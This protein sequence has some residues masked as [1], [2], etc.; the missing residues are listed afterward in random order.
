MRVLLLFTY[1]EKMHL[2]IGKNLCIFLEQMRKLLL[3]NVFVL[4]SDIHL[5]WRM[6]F[7]KEEDAKQTF[8]F[9]SLMNR[10]RFYFYVENKNNFRKEKKKKKNR[11]ISNKFIGN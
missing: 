8:I 10:L 11:N 4:I 1:I 7:E 3:F 5:H 6:R 9:M 2:G